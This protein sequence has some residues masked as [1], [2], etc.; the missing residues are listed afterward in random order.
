MSCSLLRSRRL[1]SCI[2]PSICQSCPCLRPS[3]Y[4]MSVSNPIQFNSQTHLNP[5]VR[6]LSECPPCSLL[7]LA[8]VCHPRYC[9]LL[10]ANSNLLQFIPEK[11]WLAYKIFRFFPLLLSSCT[12]HFHSIS[13][14][15]CSFELSKSFLNHLMMLSSLSR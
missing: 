14:V 3:R 7:L 1:S 9:S 4:P 5:P 15:V 13:R 11:E 10:D 6:I 12:L 8:C 2:N